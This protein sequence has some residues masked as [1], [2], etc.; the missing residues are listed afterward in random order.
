MC[1]VQTL[2][3]AC[4]PQ[5]A[6]EEFN[7][8]K[9]TNHRS[10]SSGHGATDWVRRPCIRYA[11]ESRHALKYKRAMLLCN[12]GGRKLTLKDTVPFRAAVM[13]PQCLQGRGPLSLFVLPSL[14]ERFK[15]A[16]PL[17]V[18]AFIFNLCH[19]EMHSFRS[20]THQGA[21]N[22]VLCV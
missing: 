15:L 16:P 20:K 3:I 9:L 19:L 5:R 17:Q 4:S 1:A 21:G 10:V 8:M 7:N 18:S 22:Q 12:S 6:L 13:E 14:H 11:V 2:A